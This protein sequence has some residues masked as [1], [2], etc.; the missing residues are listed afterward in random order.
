[1]LVKITSFKKWTHTI[2]RFSEFI[3]Q[4]ELAYTQWETERGREGTK[5]GGK[6]DRGREIYIERDT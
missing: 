1:M 3:K 2:G 6:G 5:G 4:S